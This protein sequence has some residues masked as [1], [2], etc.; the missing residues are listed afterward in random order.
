M[1]KKKVIQK[2]RVMGLKNFWGVTNYYG[3]KKMSNEQKGRSSKNFV[4]TFKTVVITSKNG[5]I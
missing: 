2:F 5:S 1:S 3:H 4:Y